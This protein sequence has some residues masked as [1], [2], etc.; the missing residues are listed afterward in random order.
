MKFNKKVTLAVGLISLIFFLVYIDPRN[1]AISLVQLN[2][3]YILPFVSI[4]MINFV[5]LTGRFKMLLA[6][7]KKNDL[8]FIELFKIFAVSNLFGQ[9]G[10]AR[11]GELI[12]S[13]IL[14]KKIQSGHKVGVSIVSLEKILSL[15]AISTLSVITIFMLFFIVDL[16]S[17]LIPIMCLL[18]ILILGVLIL[19]SKK[20]ADI[21]YKLPLISRIVSKENAI[22]FQEVFK[23]SVTSKSVLGPFALTF[24]IQFFAGIRTYIVFLS[25][26]LDPLFVG[27]LF[28]SFVTLI[29]GFLSMIPGG[30][31]SIEISGAIL[32]SSILGIDIFTA[33]SVLLLSRFL[34][35]LTDVPI[36]LIS[37]KK[38]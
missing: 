16:T 19:I 22:G 10:P 17:F 29:I 32:Y 18:I 30:L 11:S 6:N 27:V 31:G 3:W 28:I 37:S 36:G 13:V 25:L 38:L 9:V 1:I 5:L 35:Y 8:K 14:N 7:L 20:T 21:V 33:T 4:S 34:I 15:L 2:P 26:G 12:R 23:K 24:L